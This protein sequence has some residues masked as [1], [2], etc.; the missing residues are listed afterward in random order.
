MAF[1]SWQ[2]E[3]EPTLIQLKSL[4]TVGDMREFLKG[5]VAFHPNFSRVSI[6]EFPLYDDLAWE[7]RN[8][9]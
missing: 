5:G 2:I 4:A 7:D 8:R 6:S 3:D 1:T 9:E